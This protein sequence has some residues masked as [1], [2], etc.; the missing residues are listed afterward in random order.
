MLSQKVHEEQ[1]NA[2]MQAVISAVAE[3]GMENLST[4]EISRR[5]GVKEV[6]I[7]RY[8][9]NKDDMVAKTF[10]AEDEAFLQTVLDSLPILRMDSIDHESCCRLMFT[11]CWNY[12]MGRPKQLIFYERYYY[13]SSFQKY[14]YKEHMERYEVLY[15]KMEPA[16][17]DKG[18]VKT[19][20]HYVFDTLLGQAMKQINDPQN[21][22]EA[23]ETCFRLIYNAVTG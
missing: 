21:A 15:K 5:C 20:L 17:A 8:F 16:F 11:K 23:A 2:L 3:D 4:R 22:D 7:Y 6:Y 12:I 19:V 10:A 18:S 13:S 14:S 9:E 1:K